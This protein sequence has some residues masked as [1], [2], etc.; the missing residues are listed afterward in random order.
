MHRGRSAELEHL[1]R[2]MRAREGLGRDSDS[3]EAERG[4]GT[5]DGEDDDDFNDSTNAPHSDAGRAPDVRKASREHAHAGSGD[6]AP[7]RSPGA[8]GGRRGRDQIRDSQRRWRKLEQ[9]IAGLITS[10]DLVHFIPLS[11]KDKDTVAHA[12]RFIDK[13]N[14]YLYSGLNGQIDGDTCGLGMALFL[15]SLACSS[16]ALG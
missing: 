6:G 5:A 14:G 1:P 4:A 16:R 8:R 15:T 2:L 3:S 12:C 10:Y 7:A 9:A 11:I 13:S